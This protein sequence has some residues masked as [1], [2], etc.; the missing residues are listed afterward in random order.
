M[1]KPTDSHLPQ[2]AVLPV[3]V[4]NLYFMPT[5]QA[6]WDEV[7][8]TNGVTWICKFIWKTVSVIS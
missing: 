8:V 4:P 1:T 7:G 5:V 3:I 6:V 2:L